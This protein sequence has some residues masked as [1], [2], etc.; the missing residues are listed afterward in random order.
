MTIVSWNGMK[1]KGQ[2][3]EGSLTAILYIVPGIGGK[4]LG[5]DE[6]RVRE[7]RNAPFR[8]TLD[9]LLK[10]IGEII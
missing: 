7:S 2:V 8:L 5:Y 4:S 6:Q 9:L 10:L 1:W 3:R